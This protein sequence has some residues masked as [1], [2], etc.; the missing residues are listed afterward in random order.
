[1][2]N[3]ALDDSGRSEKLPVKQWSRTSICYMLRNATYTGVYS[4]NGRKEKN[5]LQSKTA[6]PAIITKQ[7]FNKV[8]KMRND[9]STT[10]AKDK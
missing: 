7:Q 4:Y 6:I 10:S 3:D 8:Q 2:P 1:M 5:N 9:K